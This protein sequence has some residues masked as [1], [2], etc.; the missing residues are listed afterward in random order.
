MPTHPLPLPPLRR[1]EFLRRLLAMTG[2]SA[3]ANA[4][5][6]LAQVPPT[7][8]P[9]DIVI[10]GAG[11]AGLVSAYE[12]EQR[13][14]RV[15]ILEA[16]PRHIGGRVRTMR[17]GDGRYGEFGAM[18]IPTRHLLTRHYVAELGLPLRPFVFSNPQAYYFI[19]GER[20]RIAD[21][22][23]VARLFRLADA[24]KDKSPDD[25]W[26][27][28]VG[29]ALASLDEA[30][31]KSL[32]S[33]G[34]S[35]PRLR[36]LD[37]KTL[38][39]LCE[40]AGLSEEAI[41]FLAVTGGSE[42]ILPTAATETLREEMLEVWTQGFD[43]IVGG[44]DTLASA[45]AAKLKSKPRLGAEVIRLTQSADGRR[46]G[47]IYRV[48]GQQRKAEGD[49]LLCTL[50]CP[51]LSRLVVEP[52]F[53][54]PKWRAIRELA[55]DSSTKVLALANRR[56]W[57]ADDGIYGGGTFTDLP[58]ATAYYPSD[59]AE[60]KDPRVSRGP[61][62]L[63]ASY[64]W[65]QTA[66]RLASLA[67]RPRSANVIEHLARVH[68]QLAR[69]G[70]IRQTASWSWDNHP[71]ASGAFAWF[72]AGQHTTLY[73]DL[74]APAGRIHFAGEHASLTHTWMQGA[75]ESGLRAT[76]EMLEDAQRA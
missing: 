30:D 15:T 47:A 55:Y 5:P 57:E 22:K 72:N 65:G 31:R 23:A 64:S 32:V 14:H 63:L 62:V 11:L 59:N 33:P 3:A 13:G 75:L 2:A 43:E 56:F 48:N 7:P 67:H 16:D 19:R 29:K 46:A 9:L 74:I 44:T 8:K 60:A 20:H 73:R 10:V 24:E 35:T 76:R 61:G 39:Q 25:L 18:R 41:E 12:L 71:F 26:A 49:Y 28:S 54:G 66:R 27:E 51:V 52:G 6:A 38:Q 36:A 21:V 70:A 50:P 17:F 1:R 40:D 45:L 58:L 68:P 4:L 42:T 53:S 37:Q 34:I 69:A